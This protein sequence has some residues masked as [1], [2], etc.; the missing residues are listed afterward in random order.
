[1]LS[2]SCKRVVALYV[3][4][5]GTVYLTIT[6]LARM[7]SESIAHEAKNLMGY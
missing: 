5:S 7:G 4:Q 2:L 3:C 6:P 1:M